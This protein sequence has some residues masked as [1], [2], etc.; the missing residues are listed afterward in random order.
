MG[1]SPKPL[2]LSSLSGCSGM[3]AVG[4]LKKMRVEDYKL[5]IDVEADVAEE[6]PKVYTAIKM[7]FNFTGNNLPADK[8]ISAVE[9]SI[10]KYCAVHAMLSKAAPI[11]TIIKINEQ[12][13]W[14]A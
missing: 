12:D 9:K 14:N 13:V 3:D 5:E 2:L 8:V 11:K 10:T 7:T 1:P 6:H 4:I